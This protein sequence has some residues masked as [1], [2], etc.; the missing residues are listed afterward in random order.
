MNV[1]YCQKWTVGKCVR[2][3]VHGLVRD[4]AALTDL[5]TLFL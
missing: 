4:Y 1:G 2:L 5:I 3:E